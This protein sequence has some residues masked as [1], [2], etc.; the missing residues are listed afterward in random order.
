MSLDTGVTEYL[1]FFQAYLTDE[2]FEEI[3]KMPKDAFYSLPEWKRV[4]M[5]KQVNLF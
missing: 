2:D 5:K 3:F 1:L 4:N